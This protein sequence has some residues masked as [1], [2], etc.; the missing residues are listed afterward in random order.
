MA[1]QCN[2]QRPKQWVVTIQITCRAGESLESASWRWRPLPVADTLAVQA[3]D[4]E[5]IVLRLYVTSW[6]SDDAEAAAKEA[7]K[8]YRLS[9]GEG[10]LWRSWRRCKPLVTTEVC[11]AGGGAVSPI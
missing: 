9:V 2:I 11:S 3:V 10:D 7:L 5:G 6:M 8:R 4:D 1:E